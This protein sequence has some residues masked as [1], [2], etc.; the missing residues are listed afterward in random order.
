MPR[1]SDALASSSLI[2][3]TMAWPVS[4]CP[5]VRL[6]ASRNAGNDPTDL[7]RMRAR[8][9]FVAEKPASAPSRASII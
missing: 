6:S 3:S 9:A 2:A 7:R 4:L 5:P 1:A 8:A